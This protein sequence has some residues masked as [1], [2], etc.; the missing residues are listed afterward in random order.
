MCINGNIGKACTQYANLRFHNLAHH[1]YDKALRRA[2]WSD[3]RTRMQR[4]TETLVPFDDALRM[5]GTYQQ[6][7]KGLHTVEIRSIVGSSGRYRDF[8]SNFVPRRRAFDDRWVNVAQ[9]HFEQVELPPIQLYK[10]EDDYFVVDGNHRVSV[11]RILGHEAIHASVVEIAG[12][13]T[14]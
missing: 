1:Q 4:K 9:A 5:I 8:N 12:E 2:F 14:N 11:A 10:I 7:Q 13:A 6:R 3:L